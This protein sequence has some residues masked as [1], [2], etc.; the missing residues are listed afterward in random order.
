MKG[1]VCQTASSKKNVR[2]R[3]LAQRRKERNAGNGI[4]RYNKPM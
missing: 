4:T 2:G 3:R 1:T